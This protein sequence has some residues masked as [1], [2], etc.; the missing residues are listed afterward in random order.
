MVFTG[1]GII[2]VLTMALAH[3]NDPGAPIAPPDPPAPKRAGPPVARS[4]LGVTVAAVED[5]G[6]SQRAS[7]GITS[8]SGV[9]IIEVQPQSAA[10]KAGLNEGDFLLMFAGE[11]VVDRDGFVR[12]VGRAGPGTTVSIQVNRGGRPIEVRATLD[13]PRVPNALDAAGVRASAPGTTT[14]TMTCTWKNQECITAADYSNVCYTHIKGDK[15]YDLARPLCEHAL[16]L[17]APDDIRAMAAYNIGLLDC[18]AG[19]VGDAQA[20]YEQSLKLR[21]TGRGAE[22]V[23]AAMELLQSGTCAE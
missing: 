2:I 20:R 18:H 11:H 7:Y 12:M 10:A 14:T 4:S 16:T 19:K 17:D 21:P 22:Q 3:K 1:V 13:G 15:R 5:L 6:S 23:R 9:V 8:S